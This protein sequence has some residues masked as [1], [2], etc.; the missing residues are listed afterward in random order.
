MA[1]L[2]LEV[3]HAFQHAWSIKDLNIYWRE[4]ISL[5]SRKLRRNLFLLSFARPVFKVFEAIYKRQWRQQDVRNIQAFPC[6]LSGIIICEG[7][8]IVFRIVWLSFRLFFCGCHVEVCLKFMP[9]NVKLSLSTL[10]RH[11]GELMVYVHLF[12]TSA[13]Y[14]VAS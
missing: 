8:E 4:N 5:Q 7:R 14:E 11:I 12:L 2:F 10:W 13:L 6:V 9:W 1:Y 3:Y